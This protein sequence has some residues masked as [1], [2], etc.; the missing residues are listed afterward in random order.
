[1]QRVEPKRAGHRA[2]ARG[3]GRLAG[4][5]KCRLTK[6]T[7]GRKHTEITFASAPVLRCG[8]LEALCLE[9][10]A[11]NG[12]VAGEISSKYALAS[13]LHDR[14]AIA[15]ICPRFSAAEGRTLPSPTPCVSSLLQLKLDRP[16]RTG[17][18]LLT[19]GNSCPVATSAPHRR[20][21]SQNRLRGCSTM[22][23]P[24]RLERRPPQP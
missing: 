18:H 8:G 14:T 19:R 1:M 3:W 15:V 2:V 4:E 13:M 11:S 16:M 10:A 17:C 6:V 7:A 22:P 9:I 24:Y 20:R 23:A 12:N 5:E 21:R